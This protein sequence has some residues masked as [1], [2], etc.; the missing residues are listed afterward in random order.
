MMGSGGGTMTT[1]EW[2]ETTWD[3]KPAAEA[4]AP[5]TTIAID[6]ATIGGEIEGEVTDRWLM[7]YAA[8]GTAR[9]VGLTL[10]EGAVAGRAGTLVLQHEGR[11]DAEGLHTDFTVVAGSG[12]GE[13]SQLSGTGTFAHSGAEGEPTRYAFAWQFD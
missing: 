2:D 1:R 6:R 12:T 7:S 8:D 10:V 9:F 5:K 3:G 4:P 11:F 13:L